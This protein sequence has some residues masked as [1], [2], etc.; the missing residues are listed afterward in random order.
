MTTTTAPLTQESTSRFVQTEK[1]KI[2]YNEAGTGHPVVFIHGGGPGATG[3][4]NFSQNI[5]VLQHKYRCLAI[6][7]PGFGLSDPVT[8][9]ETNNPLALKLFLD[10]LGIE[11]AALV[12]NSMGGAATLGFAVEYND[13]ITHIVTMGAAPVGQ[14]NFTQPGGMMEGIKVLNETYQDPSPANFRRL[15]Q[16]MVYDNSF[17]TDELLEQR[18]RNALA[19][20]EH[21]ENRRAGQGRG[22]PPLPTG[23]SV[24]QRLTR[25]DTPALIIHG[26]DDRAVV[27]EASLEVA[28]AL[29]NSR[30]L[31]FNRCGHWAQLEHADEF[32]RQLDLFLSSN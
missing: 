2:H 4:S 23:P 25:V 22:A 9:S 20:P 30:L 8:P 16:V 5:E 17:V 31:V 6:D 12:G 32:T 28:T 18:S 13:R 11:K 7:M 24:L 1:W 21:L 29:K 27:L 19:R 15:L 26:R 3:W 10:A 14:V